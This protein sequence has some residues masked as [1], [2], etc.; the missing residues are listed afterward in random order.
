MELSSSRTV[1]CAKEQHTAPRASPRMRAPL[2]VA[3]GG[4]VF[5]WRVTAYRHRLRAQAWLQTARSHR[6]MIGAGPRGG[7]RIGESVECRRSVLSS[8]EDWS[9]GYVWTGRTEDATERNQGAVRDGQ[10]G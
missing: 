8:I 6:P 7:S 1:R 9:A 10:P 2:A 5:P 4:Q 3:N